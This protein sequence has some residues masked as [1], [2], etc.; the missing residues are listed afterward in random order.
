M[1]DKREDWP[2]SGIN[3]TVTLIKMLDADKNII[4]SATGFFFQ[5][6]EN[7]YL[8]TNRHVVIKESENHYPEYLELRTH[9]S[10]T[11]YT[12]NFSI[13]VCLYNHPKKNWYE[14]PDYRNNQADVVVLPMDALTL[15]PD[16]YIL[17]NK[18]II[19]FLTESNIPKGIRISSFSSVLIAGYPLGFHD[20]INN[21]PV[22]RKGM[23]ASSYPINFNQQ[24]YFLID[25]ILHEGTSGSPVMNSPDNVLFNEK[26]AF[27]SAYTYFL[28]I[29]SAEYGKNGE[30]LS[31]CIVW[32]PEII[33][34]IIDAIAP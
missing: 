12:S 27:H 6:G 21:L 29:H 13:T 34:D 9:N 15:D 19:N 11:D 25:A 14:H 28:G 18:S 5:H 2:I 23:I 26:G 20:E 31:L 10:R 8:V 30:Q 32:Y 33:I 4:G 24:P 17:F 16:N 7:E 22:F 3:T 1:A